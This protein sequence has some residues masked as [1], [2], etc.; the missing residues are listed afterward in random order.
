MLFHGDSHVQFYTKLPIRTTH[1]LQFQIVKMSLFFFYFFSWK[2]IFVCL[3]SAAL[4]RL[5]IRV[6]RLDD[7]FLIGLLLEAL[8]V[9]EKAAFVVLFAHIL[10]LISSFK[11]W[12]VVG[13]FRF[14]KWVDGRY[15]DIFSTANVLATFKSW[16]NCPSKFWSPC[17]KLKY[18]RMWCSVDQN[19]LKLFL[20]S[21]PS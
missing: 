17:S 3:F 11:T 13:I 20:I 4:C 9:A 15:L 12:S 8:K 5:N 1:F 2:Y 7:F 18:P 14:L 6:T 19:D 10:T 21:P 16:A